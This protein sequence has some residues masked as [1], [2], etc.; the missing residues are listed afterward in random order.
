[1]VKAGIGQGLVH[2]IFDILC[3][4]V[5]RQAGG[6]CVAEGRVGL[7]GEMVG[8]DVAGAGGD[9]SVHILPR[10]LHILAGQGI[11]QIDVYP[12]K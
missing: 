9:G 2:R 1:M 4:I 12:L 10:R 11:H 3:G 5:V 8:A 7:H 6:R